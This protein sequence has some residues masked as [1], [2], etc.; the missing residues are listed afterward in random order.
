ML[1]KLLNFKDV[2]DIHT[3]SEYGAWILMKIKDTITICRVTSNGLNIRVTDIRE[4]NFGHNW[5]CPER[6]LNAVTD[7]VKESFYYQELITKMAC[8]EAFNNG[9]C[10]LPMVSDDELTL[11]LY[12]GKQ[13]YS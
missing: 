9:K 12:V 5:D 1:N 4:P 2:I 7:D 13:A 11:M 3:T 10:D 6:F 8:D